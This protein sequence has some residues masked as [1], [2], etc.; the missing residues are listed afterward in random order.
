MNA[1]REQQRSELKRKR[2]EAGEPE[3]KCPSCDRMGPSS[4]SSKA[5]SNYKR[6]IAVQAAFEGLTKPVTTK[7][8]LQSACNHELLTREIQPA[9][10]KT[11][12]LV[13]VASPFANFAVVRRIGSGGSLPSLDNFF[14]TICS[15]N[16]LTEVPT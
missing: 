12:N 16:L 5:S 1:K 4:S 10:L 11:K 6:K 8:S 7:S 9:V 2:E 15:V 14:L 3:P 13:H